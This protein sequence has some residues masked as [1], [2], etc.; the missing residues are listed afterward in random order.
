MTHLRKQKKTDVTAAHIMSMNTHLAEEES[1]GKTT[2]SLERQLRILISVQ[3]PIRRYRCV[4]SG[5]RVSRGWESN[6]MIILHIAFHSIK[7]TLVV[8]RGTDWQWTRKDAAIHKGEFYGGEMMR[9]AWWKSRWEGWTWHFKPIHVSSIVC[10]LQRDNTF[11]GWFLYNQNEI[12]TTG[13]KLI[14]I[15][16]QNI[17]I[18]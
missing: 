18:T 5:Y 16:L 13:C 15:L 9:P 10:V 17:N 3:W 2:G 6:G 14:K 8:V 1:R 12:M 7:I 11:Q 4:L